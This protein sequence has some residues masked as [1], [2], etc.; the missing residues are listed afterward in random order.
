MRE[1]KTSDIIENHLYTWVNTLYCDVNISVIVVIVKRMELLSF[2]FI[3]L[4]NF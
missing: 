4:I 1:S 2:I 3:F